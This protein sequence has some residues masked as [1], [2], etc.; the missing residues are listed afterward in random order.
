[1]TDEAPKQT[2]DFTLNE[3][4]AWAESST[5]EIWCEGREYDP[6]S[7]GYRPK[8]AYKITTT[9]WEYTDNDI[10]GAVNEVG[11]TNSAAQSLFAFLYACQEGMPHRGGFV[12]HENAD[13]FPE[14]VRE[15]AYLH[16]E[17]LSM[18]NLSLEG[19]GLS[20]K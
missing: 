5:V 9:K 14:H 7:E 8:Y 11:S 3:G 6:S 15:W 1:M 18:L 12:T 10:R 4:T 2:F 19:E 13:L 17:Q 16:C 20:D